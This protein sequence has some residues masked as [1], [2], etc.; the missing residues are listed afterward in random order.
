MVVDRRAIG[1]ELPPLTM[2]VDL[3]R[4]RF[5]AKSIGETNPIYVDPAAAQA[6]GLAGVPVPPTFFFSVGLEAPEPFAF[7]PEMG[8]DITTILHGS[9]SFMYHQMAYAGDEL[10]VHSRIAD[11]F[12]KRDGQLTFIIQESK[13]RGQR[14]QLIAELESVIIVQNRLGSAAKS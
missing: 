3:G 4:L 14:E 9:Q 6:A 13:V 11:V 5:F 8:V 2:V 12:D 1:R 10:T 7:L